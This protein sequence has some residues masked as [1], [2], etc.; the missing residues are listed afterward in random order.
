MIV[1]ERRRFK[2][3]DE[4]KD[5]WL[6]IKEYDFLEHP[7]KSDD[8]RDFEATATLAT[9]DADVNEQITLEEYIDGGE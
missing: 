8:I 1:D 3:A 4:N 6:S 7:Q 2:L 5:G 9:Y